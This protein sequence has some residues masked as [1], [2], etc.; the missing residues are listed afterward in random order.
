[1]NFYKF[2]LL[3]NISFMYEIDID[4]KIKLNKFYNK[5]VNLNMD[6]LG[7]APFNPTF[8]EYVAMGIVGLG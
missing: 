8:T 2:K 5:Y 1:M 3:N 4:H 6:K 7:M